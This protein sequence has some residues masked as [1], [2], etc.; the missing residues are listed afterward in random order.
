MHN[1]QAQ[2]AQERSFNPQ[3]REG[4]QDTNA[5][6][7]DC[8]PPSHPRGGI[9]ISKG[10]EARL[11]RGDAATSKGKGKV[12]ASSRTT[13]SI[14]KPTSPLSLKVLMSDLSLFEQPLLKDPNEEVF[15]SLCEV[16]GKEAIKG[17]QELLKDATPFKMTASLST[18]PIRCLL[19][20]YVYTF[21]LLPVIL[22]NSPR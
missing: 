5:P 20:I 21:Y 22:C 4:A 16:C 7:K 8:H 13:L 18:F 14:E 1:H 17:V 6:P 11:T 3:L 12:M 15:T 10:H 2:Q 9:R 19:S